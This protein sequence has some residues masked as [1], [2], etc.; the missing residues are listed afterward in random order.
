[1]AVTNR[2]VYAATLGCLM[3]MASVLWFPSQL[4]A[5]AQAYGFGPRMLGLLGSAEIGGFLLG[6]FVG[7]F[8]PLG[9]MRSWV[10]AGGA[11]AIA[12]NIALI[13]YAPELPFVV[14]RPV[15]SFG[16]GL[17]FAYALAICSR[18]ANPT[19]NFGIF[20]GLMS[21]GMIV[22]FQLVGRMLQTW[23]S[24]DPV[25]NAQGAAHVVRLLFAGYVAMTLGAILGYAFYRPTIAH[26]GASSAPDAKVAVS[27]SVV[28]VLA[29][30]ALS[31]VAQG[32]V[33]AFLQTMGVSRGFPVA[34]VAN[35]MS[36][37]PVFGVVGAFSA[38]AFPERI[39]RWLLMGLASL[40][41]LGGYLALYASST[42]V[43]YAVGCAIAG[44]YWNFILPLMLGLLARID[45]SGRGS[46]WG[47]SL[48]SAGSMTGAAVAGMLI[49]GTNYTPVAWL[50]AALM[51][52]GFVGMMWIERSQ[53]RAAHR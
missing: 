8:P 23:S 38:G 15:A 47:G 9:K 4:G 24:A 41:M 13:L 2:H 49:V 31:F 26:A 39:P 12:V 11:I 36:A 20:T 22:G 29:A 1:M 53:A 18:S 14:M 42:L 5:L 34:G 40:V 16:G 10:I 45:P 6:T 7:S 30:I 19:R 51:A 35:A 28:V 48:T 37:W 50:S 25:A 32:G 17:A 46:V 43:W 21:V 52:A 27:W 33:F 3:M 44:M